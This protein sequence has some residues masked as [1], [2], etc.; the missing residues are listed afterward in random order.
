MALAQQLIE[1]RKNLESQARDLIDRV[2]SENRDMNAEENV[3]FGKITA[4]M[5]ALRAKSDQLVKFH[6]DSAAAEEALR[7]AGHNGSENRDRT[8]EEQFRSLAEGTTRRVEMRATPEELRALSKGTAT[9]GGNTVPT[10]FVA[11]LMEHLTETATLL[12]GGATILN[13]NSGENIEMPI[14]TSHGTA[15]LVA[16]AGTIAGTDPAFGKRTLGSYKYG[17]LILVPNELLTD[18]AVDLE[19]Y[20]ARQAGRAVGNAF[21]AHLLTGTGTGQPTGI[22]TS[23][24]LGAT[25][26][27]GTVGAPTFDNMID[28]FYSVIAPYRNSP[29]AGWLIK[30]STAGALRKLK[31]SSGRYLWEASVIAGTPDTILAKPVYTDPNVAATALNAKSVVFGDLSTYTVRLVNGVRFER[32]DDFKFDTDVVAFRCL[33]RGDGLLLDQTGAVKYLVGAAT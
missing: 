5:D 25:S 27:T 6:A 26:A 18:T 11:R 20:L 4:D 3:Q 32:S 10:S 8:V 30:D 19:G 15:A 23:A 16:E 9:A 24:T 22:V 12:R 13:T 31:D 1:R 21:G 14:T 7:E 28:L 33:I 2:A 17:E 29:D